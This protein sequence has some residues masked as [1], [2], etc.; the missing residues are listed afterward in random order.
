MVN[1]LLDKGLVTQA[2]VEL[3]RK[4]ANYPGEGFDDRID[5][6]KTEFQYMCQYMADGFSDPRRNEL[7][8]DLVGRLR[9]ISYDLAVRST[10]C[11]N[12]H[13]KPYYKALANTDTSAE[14]LQS[15]LL[16]DNLSPTDRHSALATAFTVLLTSSHW[17]QQDAEEWSV[18]MSSTHTSGVVAA[19]L[20]SALTVSLLENYSPYKAQCLA[21]VY[22]DSKDERTRQRA[23]VG[24]LISSARA[25]NAVS[26]A[27]LQSLLSA[28]AD[29]MH[30][31]ALELHMQMTS[32]ANVDN[33]SR[34]IRS[35]IIPDILK[36]QPFHITPNGVV[37]ND[38]ATNEYDPEAE[39]RN[40]DAMEKSVE[41]MLKM[42]KG[43]AD[44]FFEGFSQMKRFPFFQKPVNWFV[45]F[46]KTH[47]D[48]TA[49]AGS[50]VT[51]SKFVDRVTSRGPFCE[52]DKYSF[53]IAMSKVASQLPENMRSM[54]EDGDLGPIGMHPEGDDM[55]APSFLRLQYLQDLYRFY[56]LS[57]LAASLYNPFSHIS[58]CGV[59]TSVADL[60][61]DDEKKDMCLYL[62]KKPYTDD[63]GS[64]ATR[65]LA[66]F[67][68]DDSFEYH[69]CHAKCSA[70]SGDNTAAVQHYTRCLE[71]KNGHGPSMRGIA[72][73][74]YSIG[75]YEK[76]AF[77]YDALHTM[78]P[79]RSAYLLNYSMA[80]VMNGK[81]EN[82]VAELYRLYYENAEDT[83]I[84]N[85]LLWA[86][87]YAGRKE[88][89]LTV[90]EKLTAIQ[91][92]Q[93][94]FSVTMNIAYAYLANGKVQEAAAT[95]RRYADT[96]TAVDKQQLPETLSK[97]M[98]D[99]AALLSQYSIGKAEQA[100]II[101]LATQPA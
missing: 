42:Q 77:Y 60:V 50:N 49:I 71:L 43:G 18:F 81:A 88:Q 22:R 67:S 44:I 96:L 47:P 51:D 74:Y 35:N 100:V 16:D 85:T 55:T 87:L 66:A 45:P 101:S 52:S 21:T 62:T 83:G 32:C 20:V 46:Y 36:N 26:A 19:T 93:K 28:D 1:E 34:E 13:V 90:A 57:P 30:G 91:Q 48:L 94:D 58:E 24:L 41:K 53:I 7:F 6:C 79:Q 40:I 31:V 2:V 76:A 98:N 12:P 64:V 84:A 56:R 70:W 14:S 72:R 89:A 75:D 38:A 27:A 17:S 8:T 63:A 61:A 86:L 54:M 68:H 9:S 25:D 23:L 95:L 37:Q 5:S 99:D 69:Y 15:Q 92:V 3:K 4:A 97:A 80:M 73:A 10:L 65:L 33:D 39:N 82:T 11:E 78:F 59:W 29:G